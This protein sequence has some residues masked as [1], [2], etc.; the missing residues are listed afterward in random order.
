M[1]DVRYIH[2]YMRDRRSVLLDDGRTGTIMR[3]DTA[4]PGRQ[5]TI[6]VWTQCPTGP[7]IAKVDAGDVVG[8][9]PRQASA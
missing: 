2:E 4:F 1:A 6:S 3:V 9:V 7:C 8:P 5:I